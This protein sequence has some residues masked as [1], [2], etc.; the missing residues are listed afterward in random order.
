[1]ADCLNKVI[2]FLT[3]R[4]AGSRVEGNVASHTSMQNRAL[5]RILIAIQLKYI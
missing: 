5:P 2:P 4:E 1:M 3:F